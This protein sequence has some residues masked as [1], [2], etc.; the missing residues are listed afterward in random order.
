V[1]GRI[2][3]LG[4]C[5]LTSQLGFINGQWIE[6]VVEQRNEPRKKAKWVADHNVTYQTLSEHPAI[7]GDGTLLDISENGCRVGG[8][9]TLRKGVR[10]KM[11]VQG[12]AGQPLTVLT[13]CN[14]AWI[15]DNEFGVQFLWQ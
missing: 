6:V 10:L 4:R 13:N 1:T 3:R 12:G 2:Q 14:V 5:R 8:A 11:A 7:T 15:K 9:H